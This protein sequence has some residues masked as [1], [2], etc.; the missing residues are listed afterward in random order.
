M[1]KYDSAK[2]SLKQIPYVFSKLGNDFSGV[3]LDMGGGKY[4]LVDETF[5]NFTNL[6]VDP[7]NRTT[8]HNNEMLRIAQQ[9]L[10]GVVSSNVVN[11][12]DCDTA[13]DKHIS[14]CFVWCNKF[15]VPLY[16][17]VYHNGKLPKNR[18]TSKGYQRNWKLPEYRNFVE[19]YFK[20][21]EIKASI[22]FCYP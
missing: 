7:F 1:Q 10:T 8:E 20:R 11:A 21:V 4:D 18:I 13:L 22:M 3:I 17:T 15:N 14:D 5:S 16:L 19:K 9:G 2:T 12:I 6:V